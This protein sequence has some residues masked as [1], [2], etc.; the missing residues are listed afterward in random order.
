MKEKYELINQE[1]KDDKEYN[2][3]DIVNIIELSYLFKGKKEIDKLE[4]LIGEYSFDGINTWGIFVKFCY[5]KYYFSE[6]FTDL[7]LDEFTEKELSNCVEEFINKFFE[8]E[9]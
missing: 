6:K 8:K 5:D 3:Y 1:M 4:N 2:W 9:E 7:S